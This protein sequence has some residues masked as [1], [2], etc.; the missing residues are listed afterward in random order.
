LTD[1]S[2]R[3]GLSDGRTRTLMS[4]LLRR[5]VRPQSW[6]ILLALA[7]MAAAAAATAALAYQMEPVIDRVFAEGNRDALLT[8]AVTVLAIFVV[9]GI[10]TYGEA[11][12]MTYVGQRI[13]ADLQA[14]MFAHLMRADLG[15]F[16]DHAPG[17][18]ISR[19]THDTN[20]LR[21]VVS[22]TLTGIGKDSLTLVFLVGLMFYQDWLLAGIAFFAFPTA[23]LPIARIGR[24][25][26]KVSA[27]SQTRTGELSGLLDEVFQGAR[28]VKAYGMEAYETRRAAAAIERL[29]GL[30]TKAGRIRAIAHPVMETL[31]GVAIVAVIL[32]GG[33]QVIGGAKTPGAFFSFITALLL[34]Y[35]PMKRLANLNAHLQEGLAAADRVFALLDTQPQ[36]TDRPNA[37]PLRVGGGAITFE[38]VS[39]GYGD[40][41]SEGEGNDGLA[42]SDL[43]LDI[44]AG[45]TVALVGPSGAGKSTVLNLIPRFFDVDTGRVL[46]DGQDVRDVT[47]ASL[48]AAVAL[49]SQESLLFDDTVRANI[50]Y[51]RPDASEEEMIA[52]AKAADAHGFI[53][54]LPEGYDTPVGPRGVRLSGGQRQRVAIARAMLRDAPILLLDEATSALDTESERQ[55]QLALGRLKRGRTT[56][57]IAHRLSTVVSADRIYVMDRGTVVEWGTHAELIARDGAYARLYSLQFAPEAS[58]AAEPE[59]SEATRR[60]QA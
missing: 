8:V 19:F 13:V 12:I 43:D 23:V 4:R 17:Q 37:K 48:R 50:L 10:A 51:G 46:I 42:L 27:S 22:T 49:V 53:S 44:P 38:G 57:V 56:V 16:H 55:V 26:R 9:K 47:L 15:F 31:G 58:E 3:I 45:W 33:H 1:S 59:A 21:G 28:Q 11:A 29:F 7:C 32:Y 6:R 2:K 52:A 18:L 25:M 24:R 36:I 54:E 60:A 34:A 41:R 39:F 5:H 40:R 14:A 20:L 35:E 30:L